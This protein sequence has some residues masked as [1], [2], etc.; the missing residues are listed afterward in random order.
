MSSWDQY[1]TELVN[2]V[3]PGV[4]RYWELWNEANISLGWRGDPSTLVT[5]AADAKA[6]IKNVDPNA[7]ILSPSTTINFETPT[8]CA[9]ADP[10]CGSN[11]M[12][13]WLA[14]GGSKSIDGIA[15]HGYPQLTEA[16][17]VIQGTVTLLQLAMNQNGVGSLPLLDT[18]SS[19]GLNTALPAQGDQIAFLARHLLL[20]ESMGVQGSFWF[21]YDGSN[22]GT[23]WSA[24]GGLN[25]VGNADQQVAKWIEGATLTQPCA[26]TA[27][28]PTT[29]TCGYTRPNGYSALA[30]WNTVG[31]SSFTVPLGFMQYHDLNGNVTTV[32][33]GSVGISSSPIL[34][35]TSSAF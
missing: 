33:P 13:N 19:W 30:V 3:G 17:E 5:M 22:W 15:F 35:E 24:T 21:D 4:I 31:E 1:V 12:N 9:T 20:E 7:I 14:A 6:I 10:R 32:S 26:A 27:S 25:P 18:E 8:E 28:D 29:F 11:W 34:L 16:P 23:L 2:H